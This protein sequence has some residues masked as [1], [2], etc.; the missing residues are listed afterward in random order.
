MMRLQK[1]LPC[2]A[3]YH[4]KYG[5]MGERGYWSEFIAFAVALSFPVVYGDRACDRAL[6][7]KLRGSSLAL[8]QTREAG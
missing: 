7:L 3:R 4:K 6:L 2:A 5:D 8:F 1:D